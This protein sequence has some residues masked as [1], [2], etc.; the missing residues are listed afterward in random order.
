M[1]VMIQYRHPA[2]PDEAGISYVPDDAGATALKDQLERR[3]F[4]IVEIVPASDTAILSNTPL[5]PSS[6]L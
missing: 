1:S 5:K 3:G 2:R 4:Q 6:E